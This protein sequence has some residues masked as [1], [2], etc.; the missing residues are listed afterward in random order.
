MIDKTVTVVPV[1]TIHANGAVINTQN[2]GPIINII[3][4]DINEGA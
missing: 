3:L 4:R 2:S 1:K